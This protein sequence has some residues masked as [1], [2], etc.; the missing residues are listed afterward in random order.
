MPN[1]YFANSNNI[2]Q[3]MPAIT[4]SLLDTLQFGTSIYNKIKVIAVIKNGSQRKKWVLI[5][6]NVS[7]SAI[8][9]MESKYEVSARL[10][11]IS[12]GPK[13]SN[14]KYINIRLMG[15]RFFFIAHILLKVLSIVA[16]SIS[17][18]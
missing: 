3:I 1:A 11:P 9:E 8:A 10:A 15:F 18:A 2:A 17:R 14:K 13:K 6:N 16:S 12:N 4:A 7:T 5:S